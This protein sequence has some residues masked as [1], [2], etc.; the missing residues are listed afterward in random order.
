M[1]LLLLPLLTQ[2]PLEQR[3]L[4]TVHHRSEDVS[5][6]MAGA[7]SSDTLVQIQAIRGMGRLQRPALIPMMAPHLTA[8]TATV[9]EEAADALAHLRAPF[10]A[11]SLL[12]SERTPS[13]RAALFGAIGRM[14]PAPAWAESTLLDG[15]R[16]G[17]AVVRL[18]AARGLEALYRLQRTIRPAG[19]GLVALRRA[20]QQEPEVAIRRYLMAALGTVRDRDSLTLARALADPEPLIRRLA[21]MAQPQWIDDPSPLVRYDVLRLAGSCERAS[22]ALK[23]DNPHVA[24]LAIDQIASRRCDPAP[25]LPLLTSSRWHDRSQAFLALARLLPDTARALLP[26]FAADPSPQVRTRAATVARLLG[27]SAT[28]ARLARDPD[29]NVAT[30][31]LTTVA[32]AIAA[33][34]RDHHGLLLKAAQTLKG[35]GATQAV[36]AMAAALVGLHRAGSATLRDAKMELLARL[37]EFDVRSIEP[38]L[39]PMLAD[40][41]PTVAA[42]VAEML[43]RWT[44]TAVA[45]VT[46]AAPVVDLPSLATLRSLAGATATITFEGLGQVTVALMTDVAPV[47][48]AT[49]VANADAGRFDGLTIHRIAPN[50]V[51]QGA[52]PGADEY[53]GLTTRFLPE[54]L[55]GLWHDRGTLGTSTRGRDTGDG[56]FYVNMVDNYRLDHDYTLFGRVIDGMDIVDRVV[57]STVMT[58]VRILRRAP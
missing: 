14:Q 18:G 3:I 58:S 21:V 7:A 35:S 55:G 41:D 10:A 48:V 8:R 26:R 33:L 46:I 57:E 44:G 56:Q 19:D 52:S 6:L 49:F 5:A 16:D 34:Q 2:A 50:F 28:L 30:T 17:D 25:L 38:V 20:F 54:E 29:P 47:T 27:D 45:P 11:D 53:T 23:D 43:T 12:R 40:V 1:W 32:D 22:A 51:I 4:E 15:L 9:R 42:R 31:A 37:D 24:M 39:R 36:P 13:V